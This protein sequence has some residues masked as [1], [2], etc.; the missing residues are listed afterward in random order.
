MKLIIADAVLGPP[1]CCWGF[2]K[3]GV[4]PEGRLWNTRAQKWK[5]ELGEEELKIMREV[6]MGIVQIDFT[7]YQK[8]RYLNGLCEA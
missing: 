5:G 8:K 2:I 7:F 4:C 1:F 6:G 3:K